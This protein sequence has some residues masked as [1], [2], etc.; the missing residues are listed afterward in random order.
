MSRTHLDVEVT[1]SFFSHYNCLWERRVP[2]VGKV[3]AYALP[4]GIVMVL[5]YEGDNGFDIYV[6]ASGK[7][8]IESTMGEV[9]LWTK[10]EAPR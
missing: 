5:D 7:N 3:S 9:V 1:R 8:S 2:R 6:P 4:N 10:D